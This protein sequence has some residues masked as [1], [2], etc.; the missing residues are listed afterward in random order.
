MNEAQPSDQ[1]SAHDRIDREAQPPAC[2]VEAL[3]AV[4]D[5]DD[6]RPVSRPRDLVLLILALQ[7]IA[8]SQERR[9]R[10]L[11]LEVIEEHVARGTLQPKSQPRTGQ[12]RTQTRRD[13]PQPKQTTGHRHDGTD[14]NRSKQPPQDHTETFCTFY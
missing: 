5:L 14:H 3:P 6:R 4:L 8:L 13:R 9:V 7:P 2:S 12:H 11:P 10:P 1:E